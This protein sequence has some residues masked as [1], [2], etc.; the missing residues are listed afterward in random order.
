LHRTAGAKAKLRVVD[1]NSG[2]EMSLRRTCKF[3]HFS[4][5]CAAAGVIQTTILK[6]A[7]R[8]DFGAEYIHSRLL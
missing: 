7:I 1:G 8:A 2:L 4:G 3:V 5:D 6:S